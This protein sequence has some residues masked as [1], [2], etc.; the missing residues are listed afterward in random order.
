M[1]RIT[2][3]S[4]TEVGIPPQEPTLMRRSTSYSVINSVAYIEADG[5]PIPV[6]MTETGTPS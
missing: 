3:R 1:A 4:S 2:S 6:P 5:I